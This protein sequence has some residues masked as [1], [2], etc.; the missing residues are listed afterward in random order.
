MANVFIDNRGQKQN[1]DEIR[2]LYDSVRV[3]AD[4]NIV[5]KEVEGYY[6]RAESTYG[7]DLEIPIDEQTYNVLK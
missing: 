1:L 5:T 2:R 3:E 4:I 7:S 6:L